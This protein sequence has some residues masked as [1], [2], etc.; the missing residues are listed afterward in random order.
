MVEF[1]VNKRLE[2]FRIKDDDKTAVVFEGVEQ[3]RDVRIKDDNK[4]IVELEFKR[5][6]DIA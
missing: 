2:G 6:R 4:A 5:L 1:R 3:L